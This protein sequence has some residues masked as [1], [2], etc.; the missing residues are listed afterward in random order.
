[1]DDPTGKPCGACGAFVPEHALGCGVCGERTAPQQQI[2]AWRIREL[3]ETGLDADGIIRTLAP[4]YRLSDGEVLAQL[5]RE[6]NQQ[7]S[8]RVGRVEGDGCGRA[9]GSFGCGLLMLAVGGIVTGLTY[10]VASGPGG[11]TYLVTTGLFIV[12]GISIL[13]GIWQA[14]RG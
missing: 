1:M 8:R 12:G 11:G 13:R 6:F 7:R 3:A 5:G 10:A 9:A 14:F 2:P 4:E